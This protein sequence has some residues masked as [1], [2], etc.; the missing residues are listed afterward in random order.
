VV[1]F[2][3]GNMRV[4]QT[5]IMPKPLPSILNVPIS[6]DTINKDSVLLVVEK[7]KYC[8]Q[9]YY[10]KRLI[11]RYKAVFG[12]RPMEDKLM[13][14]DRCT[15]EGA[16]RITHKNPNSKFDKFLG[17]SYPTDSTLV[18]FKKLKAAGVIPSHA[19]VG[20]AIGIHGIWQGGDDV[21]EMGVG[22]TDGCVALKNR[23]VQELYSFVGV[24]TRV[25]IRK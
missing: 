3:E 16:F 12:P 6:A 9:V 10:K 20:S 13:E 15:P 5:V 21:I 2:N 23:D 24:G 22:W 17:I 14:G 8:V 18:R 25:V 1:Q 4:T 7:S 19:R 11:R